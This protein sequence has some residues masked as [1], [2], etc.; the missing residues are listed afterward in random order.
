MANKETE[1][2]GEMSTTQYVH[3]RKKIHNNDETDKKKGILDW[4][5]E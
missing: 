3:W 5:F 1:K 4:I 2:S